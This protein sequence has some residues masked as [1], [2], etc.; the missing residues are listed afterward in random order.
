MIMLSSPI[1]T[2]KEQNGYL[3]T[4]SVSMVGELLSLI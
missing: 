4:L 1:R 2:Y 3:D